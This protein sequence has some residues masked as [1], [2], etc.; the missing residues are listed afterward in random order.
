MTGPSHIRLRERD[1]TWRFVDDQ[2][3]VLDGRSWAYLSTNE[4]GELLWRRMA[5]GSTVAELEQ[6]LVAQYG[7]DPADARRD[8]AL[9]LDDL[10]DHDLI[11]VAE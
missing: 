5:E 1:L 9:F 7:I 11:E 8:V 3:V 10:R 6:A 4:A 2:V